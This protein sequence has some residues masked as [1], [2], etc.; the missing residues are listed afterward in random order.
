MDTM[1]T[2]GVTS[3]IELTPAGTLTGLAKRGM[4]GVAT[5]A[6]KTPADLESAKELLAAEAAQREEG[7]E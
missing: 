7:T 4:T 1:T 2:M 3:L 6:V 5:V